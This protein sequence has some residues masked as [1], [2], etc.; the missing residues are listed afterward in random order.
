MRESAINKSEGGKLKGNADHR[1]TCTIT[2]G[3]VYLDNVEMKK[4]TD[5]K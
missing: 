5:L 1:G 4:A 2:Q 3:E